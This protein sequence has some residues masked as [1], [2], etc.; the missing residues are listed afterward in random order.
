MA[1]AEF[2]GASP[3]PMKIRA[4]G[5]LEVEVGPVGLT[6]GTWHSARALRLFLLLLVHRFR[7]VPWDVLLDTLWP[8]AEPEKALNNL[9][10]SIHVLRRTLEPGLPRTQPS[11]YIRFH[12]EACRLDPGEG[13]AYDVEDFE[14][15][16]QKGERLW[17]AGRRADARAPLLEAVSRYRGDF[18]TESPYEEFAAAEREHLRDRALRAIERLLEVRAAAREWEELALLSRRGLALD[19]YRESHYQHLVLAH[20]HLG[21]R[22]E[23]L[24]GYHEYEAMMINEMGLPPS[25]RMKALAERVIALGPAG[26]SSAGRNP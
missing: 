6:H 20:L 22:R 24:A 23:A 14:A 2:S 18:L 15:A 10:Q 11:R 12:N 8:E 3:P 21:H 16:L 26:R 19:P 25:E 7:W 17:H 4:L 5:Q 1:V 9:R 13:R